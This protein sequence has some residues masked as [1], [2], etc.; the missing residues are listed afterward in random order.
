LILKKEKKNKIGIGLG[1]SIQKI[2]VLTVKNIF[3]SDF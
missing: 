2:K 1:K 3:L